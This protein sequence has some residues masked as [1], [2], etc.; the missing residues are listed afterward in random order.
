[1]VECIYEMK[2]IR[3]YLVSL[4]LLTTMFDIAVSA[5]KIG[6][7]Q[8]IAML[9]SLPAEA[10]EQRIYEAVTGGNIPD[11]TGRFEPIVERQPDAAGNM[12]T[13][14]ILVTADYI[15]VGNDSD[16][17]R[18]PMLPATA[19]RIASELDAS[20]PTRKI[21]DMIHRHSAV[22]LH[23]CPMLPDS[24]MVTLPVFVEHNRLIADSLNAADYFRKGIV[25]GHKKD[26]VITNRLTEYGRVFIYGWHYPDGLPIQPLSGVHH[27]HYADYSHGVRLV[28]QNVVVDGKSWRLSELLSDPVLYRLLSDEE[29]PMQCTEYPLDGVEN[30][31]NKGG[32]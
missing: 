4:A 2:N 11:C 26:I 6:G 13:V 27:S 9:S 31:P 12:H 14:E 32:E 7:R 21:V 17:V 20:L 22:K 30:L 23:P 28:A 24:T 16:Y 29:G 3:H 5:E 15:A 1:M 10:R 19:Q 8:F 25:A 18:M